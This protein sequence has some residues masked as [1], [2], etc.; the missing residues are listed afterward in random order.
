MAIF[1]L[2]IRN[3]VTNYDFSVE[4]DGR[5]YTLRY[6]LNSRD[7]FWYQDIRT[8]DG[9]ALFLGRRIAVD[10]PLTQ[11]LRN[12]LLPPGDFVLVDL[13][14]QDSEA[15]QDTFSIDH[16]LTYLDGE[17]IAAVLSGA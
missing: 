12:K 8:E 17:E 3:D 2:P 1:D 11:R 10:T 6:Y 16:L 4:L 13:T 15:T 7:G 5:V 9:T 14:S